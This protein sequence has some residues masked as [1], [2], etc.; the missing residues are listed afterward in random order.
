MVSKRK[1]FL[2]IKLGR[3]DYVLSL[4]LEVKD[5]NLYA[6]LV[7]KLTRKETYKLEEYI[8]PYI[9][10]GKVKNF[11][12]D[13]SRLKKMDAEGRFSLF[14]VKVLLKRQK[15]SLILVDVKK[16]L[17]EKLVGYRMRIQ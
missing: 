4:N 5:N 11:Y 2:Y 3:G 17:K 7:G 14:R 15:G 13:C 9:E 16:D 12:C 6:T 8:I 1:I 10:G